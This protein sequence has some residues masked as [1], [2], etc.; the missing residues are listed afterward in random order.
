MKFEI[1]NTFFI[2]VTAFAVTLFFSCESNFKE[3]QKFNFSE[4]MPSGEADTINLKYTD[5]GRIKAIMSSPKMLDYA[6]VKYPFT[7]F[8]ESIDVTLYEPNG[9]KS[10]IRSDYAIAFKGTD[11]ID[12]RGNVKFT[13]QDG[14]FLETEQ[15]YYDQK[16]EWFF[17]EKKFKFTDSNKGFTTGEGVDFSKDLKKINYQKVYS[18]INE[19][20]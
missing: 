3:V 12:L 10:F 17:T 14:Q 16:N 7:E 18:E 20:E 15:I 5:S 9:K 6:T 4:F 11:I 13:T 1:K 19:V 8:T 2:S